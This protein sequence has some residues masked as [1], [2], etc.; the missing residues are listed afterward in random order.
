MKPIKITTEIFELHPERA[1]RSSRKADQL[2]DL[3]R[4]LL[5]IIAPAP[6]PFKDTPRIAQLNEHESPAGA[7]AV[8]LAPVV[9]F[10]DCNDRVA[11]LA[12]ASR[13]SLGAALSSHNEAFVVKVEQQLPETF[14]R[15]VIQ[16]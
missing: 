3:S 11:P 7:R 15:L 10:I 14:G 2:S 9:D 6:V 12:E 13:A 8:E 4:P 5:R 1:V 16:R